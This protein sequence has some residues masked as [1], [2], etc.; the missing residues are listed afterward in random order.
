MAAIYSM[1]GNTITE[2]LQGCDICDEAI[3]MA[4]RMAKEFG[5]PVLLDDDDGEWIVP[6]E[7]PARRNKSQ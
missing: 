3:D 2:G 1:D 4:M 6:V 7:G 5:E